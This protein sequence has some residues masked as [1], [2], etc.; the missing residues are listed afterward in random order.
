MSREIAYAYTAAW[1]A[2]CLV[3]AAMVALA[4]GS[5]ALLHR[6]YWRLLLRPW[7]VAT[8]LVATT[9]FVAVAPYTGDYTWDRGDAA[10]MAVLTFV[11][12]PWAVGVL[13]RAT[14][15]RVAAPQAY[16]AACAWLLSA[17][18]CYDLWVFVRDGVYP[19]TWAANIAASSVLYAAAG[20]LWSLTH[21]PGRGVIFAF[22]DDGWP[23]AP[24]R[25]GEWRVAA[26]ALAFIVVVAALMLPFIWDSLLE[27]LVRPRP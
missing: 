2:A 18:W 16:V 3:A 19:P 1:V 10:M 7:R 26:Y 17:S 8:F 20:L 6:P 27:G 15:R 12:A 14:R 21:V 13:Y 4:P 25:G 5:Y 11:T 22:M 24:P 23:T 9:F